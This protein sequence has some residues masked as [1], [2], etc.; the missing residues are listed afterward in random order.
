MS[1]VSTAWGIRSSQ[2]FYSRADLDLDLDI[3]ICTEPTADW[4]LNS[5]DSYIHGDTPAEIDVK[6][7]HSSAF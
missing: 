6:S 7:L 1:K 2:L 4:I 3:R 5:I